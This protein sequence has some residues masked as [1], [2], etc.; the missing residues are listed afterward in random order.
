MLTG[1][2]AFPVL[3]VA[4]ICREE[5]FGPVL[6]IVKADSL[7]DAIKL[8]NRNKC[9]L[10][11]VD[12]REPVKSTTELLTPRPCARRRQRRFGIHAE[13]GDCPLLREAH[14]G[15]SSRPQR[16]DPV[17]P[18]FVFVPYA[19]APPTDVHSPASVK[20]CSVPLPMFS[21]SGGKGS[22]LGG[23]SLY[24]PRGLDFFTQLKVSV[25]CA[26]PSLPRCGLMNPK[27]ALTDDD[28]VLARRRRA[29]HARDDR[30][31]DAQLRRSYVDTLSGQATEVFAHSLALSPLG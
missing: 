22:V 20:Y 7:D 23:S 28:G 16:P 4:D 27:P 2:R 12:P 6:V 11:R 30:H 31:A 3:T 15:G 18:H 29:R 8:I 10:A 9:K 19:R 13:W 17:S 21:W 1:C 5:I 26:V 14:R 25:P 24:G